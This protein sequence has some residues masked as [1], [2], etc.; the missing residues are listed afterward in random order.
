MGEK[1]AWVVCCEP[2]VVLFGYATD[3]EIAKE[4]PFLER[5]RMLVYWD[6]ATGSPVGAAGGG[7]QPGCRVTHPPAPR[8]QVRT[9][10]E[11]VMECSP[12]AVERW[13][14]HPWG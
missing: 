4:H 8:S 1:K 6:T 12:E 9:R 5:V 13:E 11:A 2:R 14:A 7:P 3:E 10:V